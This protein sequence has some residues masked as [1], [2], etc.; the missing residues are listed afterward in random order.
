MM[1][2]AT[3]AVEASLIEDAI[4]STG[5]LDHMCDPEVQ[6]IL[7]LIRQFTSNFVLHFLPSFHLLLSLPFSSPPPASPFSSPFL[8]FFSQEQIDQLKSHMEEL[9]KVTPEFIGTAQLVAQQAGNKEGEEEEEKAGKRMKH[10]QLNLLS[11]EWATK[12]GSAM[13]A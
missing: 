9:H 10:E 13:I 8:F 11:H 7:I 2:I 3:S 1:D 12:V 4:G 6:V 5:N